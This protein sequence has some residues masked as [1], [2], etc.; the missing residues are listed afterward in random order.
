MGRGAC[1]GEG[2]HMG[3]HTWVGGGANE[4]R[5]WIGGGCK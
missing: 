1:V 3:G 2:A 5:K 4:W